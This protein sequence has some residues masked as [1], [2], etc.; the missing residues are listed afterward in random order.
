MA[1]LA[2]EE[3]GGEAESLDFSFFTA[4]TGNAG[5]TI[6]SA[7]FLLLCTPALVFEGGNKVDREAWSDARDVD[8]GDNGVRKVRLLDCPDVLTVAKALKIPNVSSRFSTAP[9]VWNQLFGVS[10]AVMPASLLSDRAKMQALAIFSEPIVRFVDNIVGAANVMRIDATAGGKKVTL[11]HGHEDLENAVG[12]ATAA[13]AIQLV[14]NR[15]E[16][17]IHWPSELS[18]DNRNAIVEMLLA[19]PGTFAWTSDAEKL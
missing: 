9:E 14:Q 13:F 15:I 17:G 7:T 1:Q 6:V 11:V 3:L 19:Q 2:V 5:P 8:F 4:G 10:K 16:P 18:P 12:I